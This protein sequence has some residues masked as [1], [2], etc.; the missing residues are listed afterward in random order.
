[1]G[2][3]AITGTAE[4]EVRCDGV[5]MAIEFK[6][7]AKTTAAAMKASLQ[8]G[9]EFLKSIAALGMKMEDIWMDKDFVEQRYNDGDPY[10]CVSRKMKFR[11][12]FDMKLINEIMDMTRIKNWDLEIENRYFVTD[13]EKIRKELVQAAVQDSKQKAEYMAGLV[14][15]KIVGIEE[16]N[17]KK[18]SSNLAK[19]IAVP[20]F[21]PQKKMNLQFSDQL[22]APISKEYETI[23]IIWIIE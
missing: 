23:E 2:K 6:N 18:Y 17:P 22:G 4:R 3:I 16:V 12:G 15:Q 14:G 21:L 20:N 10:V 19:N 8:Q 5:E 7:R 1:M 11:F 13:I 9:E